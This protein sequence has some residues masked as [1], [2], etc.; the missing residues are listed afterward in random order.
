MNTLA[1][2]VRSSVAVS[3]TALLLAATGFGLAPAA[4]ADESQPPMLAVATAAPAEVGLAGLPVG[5]TTKVSNTGAHDTSSARLIYRIDG[6]A[7]LPSNAVSLQY[8]LSGTA[9]KTVPL[10]YADEKFSGEIP[11]TFPLAAGQSRTVQLRIGVPMGTPHNGDSNGG[12]QQLK[13]TTL[14]SNGASGAAT[15]TDDDTIKV[16]GLSTGLSG[17]PATVTAGGPAI[18]FEA[19][20]TNPTASRYENVTDTL[21]TNRYASVQVLRSGTWKTLTPVTSNA[22]ADVYG[23]DVIGK[24]ASLAAY[25]STVAKVRVTYRKDTPAGKATVQPCAFVNQGSTPFRGTTSCGDR[26]TLTMLAA[27][28]TGSTGGTSTPIPTP[29]ASATPTPSASPSTSTE[30]PS[31]TSGTTSGTSGTSSQLAKTG[32]SG[33]STIAVAAGAFLLAGAGVLGAVALRRRRTRA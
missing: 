33:T 30:A 13:L 21:I 2:K 9:W 24:D 14:V 12:T 18:S 31:A 3:G 15:D 17:V 16:D 6:G 26:A 25:S 1:R 23:F 27:G 11:E 7:G 29:T 10:T 8:R 28:S 20:V 22:E 4:S 32:S 19:T 5:F